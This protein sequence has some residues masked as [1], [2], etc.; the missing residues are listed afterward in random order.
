MTYRFRELVFY[1][2]PDGDGLDEAKP[3]VV[4]ESVQVFDTLPEAEVFVENHVK[5]RFANYSFGYKSG[6]WWA[7]TTVGVHRFVIEDC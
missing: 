1:R 2:G 6:I 7:K 3:D 5:S 4:E